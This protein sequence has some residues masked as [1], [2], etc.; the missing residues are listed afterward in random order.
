MG[1][2]NQKNGIS[3]MFTR[4]NR[5][6]TGPRDIS[7]EV[8]KEL[9]IFKNSRQRYRARRR[10][11]FLK[12]KRNEHVCYMFECHQHHYARQYESV[13]SEFGSQNFVVIPREG[14][15]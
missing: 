13:R 5:M 9:G 15:E 12:M 11:E 4:W 3:E 6:K 1:K 14:G 2:E 10:E 8:Q 7:R